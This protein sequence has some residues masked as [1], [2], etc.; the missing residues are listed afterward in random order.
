MK[1]KVRKIFEPKRRPMIFSIWLSTVVIYDGFRAIVVDYF[2][3]SHGINGWSYFLTGAIF[4]I[5]FGWAS[6][7]FVVS[8][9]DNRMKMVWI[10]GFLT[11]LAFLAPDAYIVIASQKTP[12][13]LYAG[14]AF[15]LTLTTSITIHSLRNDVNNKK[16][17][18]DLP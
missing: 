15:Y 18:K 7:R 9:V 17:E 16:T 8:L 14:L 12:A 6:F 4:S 3:S 13:I 1:S 5:I 11:F 2:F 10:F